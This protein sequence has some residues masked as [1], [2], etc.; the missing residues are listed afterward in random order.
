MFPRVLLFQ[1]DLPRQN[2]PSA[3]HRVLMPIEGRISRDCDFENCNLRLTTKITSVFGSIPGTSR[4]EQLFHS[5]L[6]VV[7]I[8]LAR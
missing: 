5:D 2:I 6:G 8:R 3:D 1:N 4:L 7:S